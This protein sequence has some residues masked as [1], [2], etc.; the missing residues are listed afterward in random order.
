M[1]S[2]EPNIFFIDDKKNE[3][4]NIIEIYRNHGYGVKFFNADP[5]VGDKMPDTNTY[6]DAVIVFLDIYFN[7]ERILDEEKCAE[8][9]SG[10]VNKNSFFILVIWSQDTDE[11]DK[12]IDKI[13][14]TERYPYVTIKKQKSDYQNGDNQWDFDRLHKDIQA[15]IDENP[16]L[17]ELASWKKS[18]KKASN[19]IIG[20]LSGSETQSAM[21]KKLQKIIIGH[22]GTSF[23]SENNFETK[24]EVLFEALD[25]ILVSNTKNTRPNIEI[26]A[27]NK[28]NL[29][30]IGEELST[31]IDSKLNSWFHFKIH[32]LPIEQDKIIPGL[33]CKVTDAN[34]ISQYGLLDDEIISKYLKF[35]I[36]EAKKEETRIENICVLLSRPCDIAQNKYGKN[37]KLLSGIKIINPKRKGGDGKYKYNLKVDGTTPISLKVLDHLYFS[38]E[39]KDVTLLFDYRYSFSVLKDNFISDFEKVN[40]FNKELLSEIQVEYSAYCSRL[41]ITQVI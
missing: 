29:Y 34:I 37:L 41:G 40:T 21:S 19:L 18:I 2:V 17:I 25:N 36:E 31:E 20:H 33:L 39:E 32:P 12:V 8:W 11:A 3:V 15:K 26:D 1:L 27:N 10:I 28:V 30:S 16:E 38:E 6:S 35:Q 7:A 4:N 13:I 24:Q 23:I 5:V 22:G 14:E 9:I